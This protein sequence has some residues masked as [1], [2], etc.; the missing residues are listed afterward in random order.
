MIGNYTLDPGSTGWED[1]D[2]NRKQQTYESRKLFIQF[3]RQNGL[4]VMNTFYRK[5][6]RKLVTYKEKGDY[7]NDEVTRY[8]RTR[9]YNP[10]KDKYEIKRR[11]TYET[12]DYVLCGERWKNNFKDVESDMEGRLSKSNADHYPL[13]STISIRLRAMKKRSH[14]KTRDKLKIPSEEEKENYNASIR[15]DLRKNTQQEAKGEQKEECEEAKEAKSERV[16]VKEDER[17]KD[18]GKGVLEWSGL[19]EW[20]EKEEEIRRKE[21]R[22][23][24]GMIERQYEGKRNKDKRDYEGKLK[25]IEK[26]YEKGKPRGAAPSKKDSVA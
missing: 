5:L 22:I 7:H 1:D 16:Y 26:P 8:E 11:N 4:K 10:E 9:V 2:Q 6:N 19:L 23:P 21:I 20:E 15:E 17:G 25:M 3:A 14:G 13:I 18:E 24:I 12:L